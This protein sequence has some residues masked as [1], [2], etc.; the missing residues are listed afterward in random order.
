MKD[1]FIIIPLLMALGCGGDEFN[2]GGSVSGKVLLDGNPIP[3]G[4]LTLETLSNKHNCSCELTPEGT[5]RINEP[6]LG[7]C[8]F[9]VR[10]SHLKGAVTKPTLIK[11]KE[12]PNGMVGSAGMMMPKG[13]GL[14]YKKIPLLY[15]SPKTSGLKIV[16]SQGNQQFDIDLKSEYQKRYT[17]QP[18][19]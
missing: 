1:F 17:C 10:T 19:E 7:E 6:P 14:I 16:I 2:R 15:E 4:A 18:L 5:Y 8:L 13:V 12:N 9:S 11:T 3:G